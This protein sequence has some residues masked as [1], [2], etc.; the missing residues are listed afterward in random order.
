[1]PG[2]W[3]RCRGELRLEGGSWFGYD[4]T[5]TGCAQLSLHS[6]PGQSS[7][8]GAV[9]SRQRAP[10]FPLVACGFNT[11]PARSGAVGT[12][13]PGRPARRRSAPCQSPLVPQ[14]RAPVLRKRCRGGSAFGT[15]KPGSERCAR[16]HGW[17]NAP[18]F[19]EAL[20]GATRPGIEERAAIFGGQLQRLAIAR[21]VLGNRRAC[22]SMR[23]TSALVL[24]SEQAVQQAWRQANGL[25]APCW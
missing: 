14:A 7:P 22:C 16:Q 25:V 24:E 13:G 21:A 6:G 18:D 11:A 20:P 12:P 2:R 15:S 10:S 1:M 9:G 8:W 23:P 4:P 17:P 5:I 3:A 19:I